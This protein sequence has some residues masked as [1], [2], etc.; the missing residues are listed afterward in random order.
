[1]QKKN[2]ISAVVCS[3]NSED[4]IEKCLQ[5][6]KKNFITEIIL[7]DGNSTD[8]T[9]KIARKYCSKILF[10]KGTGLGA[11]RNFGVKHTRGQYVLNCGSDNIMT[12]NSIKKMLETLTKNK[13][14]AVSCITHVCGKNY[15]SKA[16]NMYKKKR[17]FPGKRNIIGTPT[18]FIGS[19]LR[20]NN[21]NIYST[22]SD[23]SELCN[24]LY[25]KKLG[26]FYI[27]NAKAL[28]INTGNFKSIFSRW[29]I[30]GISDYEIFKTNVKKWSFLRKLN[31][32]IYPFNNEIIKPLKNLNILKKVYI[33]P[34]LILITLI[35][36]F[37]WSKTFI[38][39][40][41]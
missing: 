25:K 12:N 26:N 8:N 10:D 7:V 30:Y 32:I 22:Y 17:F 9:I 16:M 19:I 20:K 4:N 6:L 24:R 36:Y 1:M 35:R 29:S 34:F 13:A 28:E 21:F 37:S 23:D 38:K 33:F 31:S 3:K 40:L 5:S 18:L 2:T 27:C 39:N 11:A 41:I 15:F 14:T